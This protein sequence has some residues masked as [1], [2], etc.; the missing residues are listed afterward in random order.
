MEDIDNINL[1][2]QILIEHNK[3]VTLNEI[4]SDVII[5]KSDILAILRKLIDLDLIKK[6]LI[7]EKQEIFKYSL[8]KDLT[9]IHLTRCSDYGIDL[10]S[11]NYFQ[12]T[13]KEKQNALEISTQIKKVQKITEK[14]RTI[15][16]HNQILSHL[17]YD[18]ISSQLLLIYEAVNNQLFDY[19]EKKSENDNEIKNLLEL[20]NQSFNALRQY[21]EN[22]K[23]I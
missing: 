15:F 14:K 8:K 17:N 5:N 21:L 11:F 22:I 7:S 12:I 9:S 1:I 23:K 6:D 13:K 10:F 19:L 4:S 20:H 18:D 16:M 2:I 3:P